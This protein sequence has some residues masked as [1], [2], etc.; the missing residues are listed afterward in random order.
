M[1][2]MTTPQTSIIIPCFNE[3]RWIAKVI[4]SLLPCRA[5]SEIIVVNDGSTD[6]TLEILKSSSWQDKIKII[7]YKKNQGKGYAMA[8]GVEKARG[9]LVI[10]MDAHHLNV[11]NSHIKTLTK[12]LIKGQAD[13]VLGTTTSRLPD[14]FWRFTGFRAYFK[15]DL[16]PHLNKIKEARLG[17]EICLNEIFKKKRVKLTYPKGLVHLAKHQKMPISQV[18]KASLIQLIEMTQALAQAKGIAPQKIK[19]LIN[20][21]K[22]KSLNA[23]KRATQKLKDKQILESL[24][25]YIFSYLER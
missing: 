18:P 10:F 4:E 8:T 15:K 14:P 5:V 21:K 1:K 12:P 13:A 23:L 16:L 22:I 17:A 20:A 7:S 25:E 11:K 24:K 9:E 19:K 3:E 2:I 6:K